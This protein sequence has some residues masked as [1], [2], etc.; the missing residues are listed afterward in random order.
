M[1]GLKAHE[2]TRYLAR[3]D[4]RE[5]VFLAYGP[6]AGL[7]RETAQR[8]AAVLAGAESDVTL[9]DGA[10][11]DADPGKLAMEA[12]TGSLFGG[13][14]IIRVRGAGRSLVL[15]LSEFT[16]APEGAAIVLEAGNLPPRD[17]LR[18]LVEA[19][20]F[21]RALPCYPDSDETLLKLIGDSFSAA[22]VAA[23]PEVAAAL[24]D[25]LGN[26]R[27]ITRR[28][29]EKLVLYAAESKRLSEADVLLLCADNA[30]L[31]ID[32]IA[33]S[34]GTGRAER[35]D[36]ALTRALALAMNPQQILTMT[37]MHFAGLRRWRAEVDAGRSAQEVLD[38]ARPKPHF[39]RRT[40]LGQ[41]LRLWSDAALATAT[42]RLHTATAESRRRPALAEPILRRTLLSLSRMA[43]E[44]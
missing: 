42:G 11:L 21:G 3:P 37:L 41:Q 8:L 38:G 26:D 43:A 24:R 32:D 17:A 40:A 22:G 14:R 23:G 36:E 25:A 30:A 19:G 16:E 35:L 29:L 12:K 33:D 10:E 31:V 27:E 4:L 44:R 34:V 1:T 5:G 39:S 6:D 20:K 18:A 9:L 15:T 7:V 28:E 2:V 13:R